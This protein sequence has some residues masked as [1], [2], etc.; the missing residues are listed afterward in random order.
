MKTW[1]AACAAMLL[2][3]AAPAWAGDCESEIAEV[4]A[5]IQYAFDIDPSHLQLAKD[6]LERAILECV[7]D[8]PMAETGTPGFALLA[9][10]RDLLEIN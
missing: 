6:L 8:D 3:F 9:A 4:E 5:A 1:I 7:D 10:A 2:L